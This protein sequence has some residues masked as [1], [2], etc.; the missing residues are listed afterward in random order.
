MCGWQ[1]GLAALNITSLRQ[2]HHSVEQ[3]SMPAHKAF[4]HP[5]ALVTLALQQ[6]G[7]VLQS[8]WG[9]AQPCCRPLNCLHQHGNGT[10][11]QGAGTTTERRPGG[12]ALEVAHQQK[13]GAVGSP[14]SRYGSRKG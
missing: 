6:H 14:G 7:T 12:T 13:V 8:P 1:D 2:V 9:H 3:S 5:E 4:R 11:P 10:Q